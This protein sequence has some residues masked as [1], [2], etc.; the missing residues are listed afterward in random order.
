M[1]APKGE[2]SMFPWKEP[3]ERVP[4]RCARYVPSSGRTARFCLDGGVNS[5]GRTSAT[6][7]NRLIAFTPSPKHGKSV[8]A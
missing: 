4:W 3:K 7:Q 5:K 8:K 2:V 6:Q 1:L